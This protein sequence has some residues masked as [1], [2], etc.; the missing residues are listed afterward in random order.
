VS[1]E[2]GAR[3]RRLARAAMETE[4]S[5]GAALQEALR[6]L[7]QPPELG[8][9]QGVFVS[10][11]RK[12][13]P[14]TPSQA[15]LRGCRGQ[16][17]AQLPL[18][19]A[20]VQAAL[21]AAL[22]DE[23]FPKVKRDELPELEI[24]VTLLSPVRPVDSPEAFRFGRDGLALARDDKGALFLPQ[25]WREAGWSTEEALRELALKARLPQEGWRGARLAAFEGQVFA[26]GHAGPGVP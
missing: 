24:E 19:L 6:A 16:V 3:L 20:V 11:F 23:R 10:L 5:G 9:R 22:H 18:D 4:L 13:P 1:N 26:E 12:G 15:R 25:V 8:R 17:E 14:G 2:L 7:G 21:E